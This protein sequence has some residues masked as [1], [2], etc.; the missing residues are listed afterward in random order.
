M[1]RAVARA[2]PLVAAISL[3]VLGGCGGPPVVDGLMDQADSLYRACGGEPSRP[4]SDSKRMQLARSVATNLREAP[5]RFLVDDS[6]DTASSRE[7]YIN[8]LAATIGEGGCR[9]EAAIVL[10]AR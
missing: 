2:A 1:V 3:V 6:E 10:S 7:S 8:S 9:R 5:G 4:L